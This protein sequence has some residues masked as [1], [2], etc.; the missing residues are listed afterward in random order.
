MAHFV[1]CDNDDDMVLVQKAKSGRGDK[2]RN[3]PSRHKRQHILPTQAQHEEEYTILLEQKG[4]C[5]SVVQ[6]STVPEVKKFTS[7]FRL[8]GAD[9]F[10]TEKYSFHFSQQLYCIKLP[11]TLSQQIL[12]IASKGNTWFS[13]CEFLGTSFHQPI[14]T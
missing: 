8:Q 1:G 7:F 9:S 4:L 11:Q 12:N 6:V 14:N 10:R 3:H 5:L 13:S 2:T